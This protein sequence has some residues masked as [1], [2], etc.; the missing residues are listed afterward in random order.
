MPDTKNINPPELSE[1]QFEKAADYVEQT[2]NILDMELLTS[3]IPIGMFMVGMA[4]FMGHAIR[5]ATSALVPEKR[6]EQLEAFFKI[7]EANATAGERGENE[8]ND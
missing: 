5:K 3:G 7:M 6:R 1:E 4:R 2:V 8:D